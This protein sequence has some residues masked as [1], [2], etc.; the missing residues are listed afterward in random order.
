MSRWFHRLAVA[1]VLAMM[2]PLAAAAA[3]VAG[4]AAPRVTVH[5]QDP[6]TFAE[7]RN[8]GFGHRYDHGDYMQ[9]LRAFIVRTATPLLAPGERLSITFTDIQLAGN[10]EPWR[11][12]L[13]DDVRFMRDIYPPR[14]K[15]NFELTGAHGTLLRHGTRELT[16][17]AYLQDT[18]VMAIDTDPLAYDKAVLR[19]WLRRGPSKW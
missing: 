9:R 16:D 1:L 3:S 5:Y 13:W 15:L 10:Y 12:P 19:R 4:T 2:L 17:L 14:F 11:G 18:S 7:S 6:H 8:A